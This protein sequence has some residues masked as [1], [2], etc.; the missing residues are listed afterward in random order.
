MASSINA[1][2]SGPGGVITTADNSGI[3]NIQTAA[4]TALTI[5]GS[6]NVGIGSVSPPGRLY[7]NYSTNN[8]YN[9]GFS[10]Q[11]TN[12]GSSA[13][14][15]FQM[16]ND[17][18]N[19]GGIYL[20]SSTSGIYGGANTMNILTVDSIPLIFGTANTERMRITSGGSVVV[21][22]TTAIGSARFSTYGGA[23]GGD[24][25]WSTKPLANITYNPA[26]FYNNSSALIGYIQC[27]TSGTTFGTSSDYRLKENITPM[28]DALN[29]VS[30]LK[31]CT[32]T[33]KADGS[34][35]Q[36]F[37]AHELQEVVPDCVIGEKDAVNEDGSIK[38]QAID[39]SFLVATLTA[40][41]QEL[42]AKVETQAAQIAALQ[43]KVGA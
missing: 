17:A 9:T 14:A 30:Q 40:A 31:P 12:S 21:A 41:I 39:T 36:G 13:A 32:Y 43:A 7:V 16:S 26:V 29:K 18:N 20:T 34:S 38:P 3:L 33:W 1:S 24:D 28:V 22:G 2:T 19:R 11:N 25:C 5:D 37:I 8:L 10:V 23:I 4:T 27:S 42:N 15:S 6:Q 35:G